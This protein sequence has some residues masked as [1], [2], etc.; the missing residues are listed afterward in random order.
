[1]LILVKHPIEILK[2]VPP[3]LNAIV[4]CGSP[5][6]VYRDPKKSNFAKCAQRVLIVGIGFV[7]KGYQV[8][9]PKDRIL[10]RELISDQDPTFTAEIWQ[11]VTKS[12]GTQLK[13]SASDQPETD[14]QTTVQ[15]VSSKDA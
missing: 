14:G 13:I 1:M 12:L 9:L 7:T 11:T 2:N 4:V 10:P 15:I 5:C 6:S 8:F 3:A